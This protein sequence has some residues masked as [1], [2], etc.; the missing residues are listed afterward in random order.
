M[1]DVNDYRSILVLLGVIEK[2]Y[3]GLLNRLDHEKN[4]TEKETYLV[5]LIQEIQDL[6]QKQ[7]KLL[8]EL[9]MPL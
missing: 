8:D 4:P 9:S 6:H 3:Q 2:K 1:K 5:S 7:E